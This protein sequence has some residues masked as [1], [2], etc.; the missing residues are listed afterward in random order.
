MVMVPAENPKLA[1]DRFQAV[2]DLLE[3]VF[4]RAAQKGGG[5]E[6]GQPQFFIAIEDAAG[7]QVAAHHH[8]R[9]VEV[10]ARENGQAI[11]Q[12]AA[13]DVFRAGQ[14]VRCRAEGNGLRKRKRAS[15]FTF[16]RCRK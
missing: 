9:A 8:R 2:V 14:G 10:R 6:I 12:D 16:V 3:G 1:P 11:G 15:C 13:G 5:G 7:V 4:L